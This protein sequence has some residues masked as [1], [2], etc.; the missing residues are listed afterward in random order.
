MDMPSITAPSWT[1]AELASAWS[2]SDILPSEAEEQTGNLK[3]PPKIK[4]SLHYLFSL[5]MTVPLL[6]FFTKAETNLLPL[7]SGFPNPSFSFLSNR[8]AA[9]K[10]PGY[11]PDALWHGLQTA[12]SQ[13]ALP[14]HMAMLKTAKG[15][16]VKGET[17]SMSC[18]L[19]R[20]SHGFCQSLQEH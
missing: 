1:Q 17:Q 13:G 10:R 5:Y 3:N 7:S 9:L 12:T 8:E 11:L 16:N 19:M 4:M 20:R 15:E 2:H 14:L 6:L 18:R